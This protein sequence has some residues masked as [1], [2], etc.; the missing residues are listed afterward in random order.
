MDELLSLIGLIIGIVLLFIIPA[1]VWIIF[2][3]G[4]L[5]ILLV[6]GAIA[7]LGALFS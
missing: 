1:S 6:A 4:M 3:Q 7:L 2:F 5:I